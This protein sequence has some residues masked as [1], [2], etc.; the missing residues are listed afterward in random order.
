[1][2][3]AQLAAD[4]KALTSAAGAKFN[5]D[6]LVAAAAASAAAGA[7]AA[8]PE[9]LTKTYHNGDYSSNTD[10]DDGEAEPKEEMADFSDVP[11][12][13]VISDFEVSESASMPSVSPS[14]SPLVRVGNLRRQVP[15]LRIN[16]PQ[17]RQTQFPQSFK[18]DWWTRMIELH[19]PVKNQLQFYVDVIAWAG[20]PMSGWLHNG[21][22]ISQVTCIETPEVWTDKIEQP[23]YS[24][25]FNS[26]P[27]AIR[28]PCATGILATV[29]CTNSLPFS[30]TTALTVLTADGRR[31]ILRPRSAI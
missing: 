16:C 7:E 30:A 14:L 24:T 3:L 6:A 19:K 20:K 5:V 15:R 17:C 31:I 28:S 8:A 27:T 23:L 11:V 9:S 21:I 22:D 29:T 25:L 1:M 12:H 4:G 10:A 26:T 2:S 13:D 18:K